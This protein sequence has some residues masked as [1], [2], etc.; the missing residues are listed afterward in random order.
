[1]NGALRTLK[2]QKNLMI[3]GAVTLVIVCVLAVFPVNSGFT[4]LAWSMD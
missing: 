4:S 2:R 1:M 3:G